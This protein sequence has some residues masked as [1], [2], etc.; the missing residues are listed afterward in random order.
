MRKEFKLT[1][2]PNGARRQKADHAAL[3]VSTLEIVKVAQDCF[4]AGADEIHLH[5]RED[6]GSHSLDVGRYEEAIKAIS[7]AVPAMSIQVTTESAGVFS[8]QE[9]YDCLLKLRPAAASI[10]VRE[11]ARDVD[12]AK[13]VYA[14]S[15]ETQT[16]VQHILYSTDCVK[17]LLDWRVRGIVPNTMSDVIFVLGQYSPQV[18]GLPEHL[19]PFLS[20]IAQHDLDWTVCAFGQNEHACLRA[21]VAQGGNVR[22]GFENNIQRP[23]GT[24]FEDN[25]TSVAEFLRSL[26][27]NNQ[28]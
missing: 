1:V 14:L 11:M 28:R 8:V 17:Q 20:M 13:C 16:I 27:N 5:V 24:L 23:D 26:P 6:D 19:S 10:S 21:A 12:L 2:A 4:Q 7:E 22:I 25:A 3:P 18:L 15:A 9:Q